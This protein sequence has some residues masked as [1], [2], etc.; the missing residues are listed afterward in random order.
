MSK[1]SLSPR[2]PYKGILGKEAQFRILR[3]TFQ[4]KAGLGRILCLENTLGSSVFVKAKTQTSSG[5]YGTFVR[6]HNL[7]VSTKLLTLHGVSSDSRP[8]D[9]LWKNL[10]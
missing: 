1:S 4:F 5:S 2:S 9:S 7:S 10:G 8:E 6:E 3:D